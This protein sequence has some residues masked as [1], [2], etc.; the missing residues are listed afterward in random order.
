[1]YSGSIPCDEGID[2]SN[3]LTKSFYYTESYEIDYLENAAFFGGD[4]GWDAQ[5]DTVIEFSA[6]FGTDDW[7]GPNPEI[8]EAGRRREAFC[9]HLAVC[10]PE[11]TEN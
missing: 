2:I 8:G 9:R 5:G 4:T 11:N 1:M 7:I 10:S 3:W 6:I